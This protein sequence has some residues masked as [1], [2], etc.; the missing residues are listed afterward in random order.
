MIGLTVSGGGTLPFVGSDQL[1]RCARE[2]SMLI[3]RLSTTFKQEF[4]TCQ[5]RPSQE[6]RSSSLR[7]SVVLY[8]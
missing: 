1:I 8:V 5:L 3:M 7:S 4:V 6:K 2:A